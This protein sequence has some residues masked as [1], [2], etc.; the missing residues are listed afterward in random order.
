M[1]RPDSAKLRR[2]RIK[3]RGTLALEDR[4]LA[5]KTRERYFTGVQKI[6]PRL[7]QNRGTIDNIISQWIEDEYSAGTG[8]ASI[9]DTLSGLHHFAPFWKGKLNRSWRLFRLWKRLEKPKQAPPF[10]TTFAQALVGRA[11]EVED[12]SFALVL[13][14]GFW[15]MLRTGELLS[16]RT[17]QLLLGKSDLVVQLGLTKSGLRRQQDENVVIRHGPTLML[18]STVL[19]IRHQ[20]H[21]TRRLLYTRGPL[22]FRKQFKETMGFF[23]FGPSFRPYSLRRGGATAHFRRYGQMERTLIR[24][25]WTTNQAAKQYIQEGLSVLTKL[26][27]SSITQN[28]VDSY[29]PRFSS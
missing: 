29:S 25:R 15:G 28:L 24:G 14:L 3:Q 27:V 4:A 13:A 1:K 7:Q 12:L 18:A 22:K 10:P 21:R 11:I 8:V 5:P 9:A 20:Q 19:A 16:L 6:M 17:N 2:K 26:S 23:K